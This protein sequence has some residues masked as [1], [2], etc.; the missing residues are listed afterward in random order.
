M[1]VKEKKITETIDTG[2]EDKTENNTIEQERTEKDPDTESEV[3]E[4]TEEI[5]KLAYIGPTLPSG[6]LK[7]NKIFIGTELEIK[8]E[9]Q[10]V[11]EK[12]PLV[13]KMIVPANKMGEKK[14]K[15]RTAGNI[16]HK[17]YTDLVSVVAGKA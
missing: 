5:V 6:Q 15:A 11:I 17:Y 13:E 8:K 10:E 9:L 14:N 7:C 3:M 16:L 1:A 2:K 4:E 12:Y